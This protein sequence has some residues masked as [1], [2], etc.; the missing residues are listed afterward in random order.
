MLTALRN[1]TV[2]KMAIVCMLIGSIGMVAEAANKV[3][4]KGS[5][6]LIPAVDSNGNMSGACA[7]PVKFKITGNKKTGRVR[8]TGEGQIPNV[9]ASDIE[10]VL[11]ANGAD[12]LGAAS[13]VNEVV[14]IRVSVSKK[15]KAK[16]LAVFFV[17]PSVLAGLNI[18]NE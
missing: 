15:G 18:A 11:V 10:S 6:C 8:L 7:F 13:L 9:S 2:V 5:L 17:S 3:K 4:V 14:R 12:L 16:L 1:A